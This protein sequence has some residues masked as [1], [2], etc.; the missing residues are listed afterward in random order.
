MTDQSS[1]QYTLDQSV[2][3]IFEVFSTN[4]TQQYLQI[5]G[6]KMGVISADSL[7]VSGSAALAGPLPLD[8]K[9]GANMILSPQSGII[10]TSS[11][12]S[13][14]IELTGTGDTAGSE[15]I[16][17]VN[18]TMNA[19]WVYV[20]EMRVLGSLPDLQSMY[21]SANYIAKCYA[22]NVSVVSS[23]WSNDIVESVFCTAC[24]M[25]RSQGTRLFVQCSGVAGRNIKWSCSLRILCHEG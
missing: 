25:L 18:Y 10:N 14:S 2:A 22:G 11:D 21:K 12:K 4:R 13:A 9:L 6:A 19:G 5:S 24:V 23:Q 17:L 20:V 16:E 3:K 1:H 15:I 7:N 8:L